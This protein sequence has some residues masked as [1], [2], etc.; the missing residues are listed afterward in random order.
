MINYKS[1]ATLRKFENGFDNE[2]SHI[3]QTIKKYALHE[4]YWKFDA[5]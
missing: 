3:L 4:Q 1:I 2:T 5:I